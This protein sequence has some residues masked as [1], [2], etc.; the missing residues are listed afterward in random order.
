MT[1]TTSDL[2]A[3]AVVRLFLPMLFL[4]LAKVAL[5]AGAYLQVVVLLACS[6]VFGCSAAVHIRAIYLAN[7]AKQGK[8]GGDPVSVNV[9]QRPADGD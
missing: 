5:D 1:R 8:N 6:T 4:Y 9:A 3:S 2:I 7:L